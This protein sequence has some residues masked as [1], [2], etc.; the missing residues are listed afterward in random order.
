MK[1]KITPYQYEEFKFLPTEFS[2]NPGV[3]AVYG[4]KVVNVVYAEEFFGFVIESRELAENYKKYHKYLWD[5][6][7]KK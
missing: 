2:G 5:N 1:G 7:A 6:V 4:H 3:I